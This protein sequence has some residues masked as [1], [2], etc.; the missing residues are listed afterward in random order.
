MFYV[1]IPPIGGLR[2]ASD[3]G[4]GARF[5][6]KKNALKNHW[7][8]LSILWHVFHVILGVRVPWNARVRPDVRRG[9][10]HQTFPPILWEKL[11]V[12][13]CFQAVFERLGE[14]QPE[15]MVLPSLGC[16][17]GWPAKLLPAREHEIKHVYRGIQYKKS[18][19]FSFWP[20]CSQILPAVFPQNWMPF[21]TSLKVVYGWPHKKSFLKAL[22]L[23]TASWSRD[24]YRVGCPSPSRF[25]SLIRRVW[26]HLSPGTRYHHPVQSSAGTCKEIIGDIRISY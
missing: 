25:A 21:L 22:T 9:G 10:I 3:S 16:L 20:L 7:D 8:S 5:N 17:F 24:H 19:F 15:P 14:A 23:S 1:F 6:R 11:Y 26:P 4:E 18:T 13:A 2:P 12:R